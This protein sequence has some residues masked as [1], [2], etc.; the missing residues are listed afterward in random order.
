[1][2]SVFSARSRGRRKGWRAG[3]RLPALFAGGAL[4]LAA[5]SGGDAQLVEPETTPTAPES[6]FLTPDGLAFVAGPQTLRVSLPS[7]TFAAPHDLDESDASQVLVT[8]LLTDGL[9]R[10][11]PADGSIEPAVAHSFE[12]SE[13]GLIWT[14]DL[15]ETTFSNGTTII[16]DDVVA[17]LN[18]VA[19]LGVSSISGPNLWPIEGWI[20]A[21]E[22]EGATTVSGI[23]AA[24]PRLVEIQLTQ[25]FEPLPEIL[26]SVSFGILPAGVSTLGEVGEVPLG[27]AVDFVP[28]DAWVDGLRLTGEQVDGEI[29]TIELFLD[30]DSVLLRAGETDLAT[31]Y[32]IDEPLDGL[33]GSAVQNSAG[34]Y[35]AMNASIGPF[36]DPLIRQAV[37][38]AIDTEALRTAWFPNAGLLRSF[39][40]QQIPGGVADAC[41]S[42]CELDLEQARTLVQASPSRDIPF[43]VDFIARG[44]A[45]RDNPE[46]VIANA[47][48]ETLRDIGLNATATSRTERGFGRLLASGELGL[49]RFGSVSTSLSAESNI[50]L[51]FH[52]NGLDNV[53][54]T[55]IVRVDE[56][57]DEARRTADP[58]TR[59]NLYSQ[60]ESILFAE[61]AVAPFVEFRHQL[62]F[63]ETLASVGLEPDG[64]LNL[65]H[66]VFDGEEPAILQGE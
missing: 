32:D 10:R 44:G 64:S 24:G 52:S 9:T 13:N 51:P 26:S 47:V 48:A 53:T 66:I 8:D 3:K 45:N 41:G 25:P 11:N 27:S 16:A 28:T 18:R 56:L 46:E 40:P 58:A 43:N 22:S 50:G 21:G 62:A 30:P 6:E 33:T 57:I 54:G 29:S 35:F 63:G 7:I 12:S 20:E 31:A 61:A 39:I 55:S 42:A 14:F 5:C 65:A 23:R 2:I 59:A 4:T 34:S 38:R 49:F 17:S 19:A 1:M 60:A 36:N 15:G 37:V